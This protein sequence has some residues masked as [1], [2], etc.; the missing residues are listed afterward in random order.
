M[1]FILRKKRLMDF[2]SKREAGE[3]LRSMGTKAKGKAGEGHTYIET[4]LGVPVHK[5]G[6]YSSYLSTG[7]KKVWAT[8]RAC[9]LVASVI[10]STPFKLTKPKVDGWEADP[11][12]PEALFLHNPNPFD[13]WAELL[14]LWTYHMKLA[15]CAFW[16]KDEIDG[17]GRPTNIYP[18]LP[19]HVKIIP[20]A[21]KNIGGF[22]YQVN[23]KQIDLTPEEVIYFRRPHP[24][25]LLLGMGDIEPS[26]DLYNDFINR[27]T[28]QEKFMEHGA[29]PSGILSLKSQITPDE[30]EWGRLKSWWNKEYG[31]KKNAGKTAFLT[32]EWSYQQLGLTQQQMQSIEYGKMTIEHIFMNHGV[33]LSIAGV[34]G[35]AN[36]ATAR[37]DEINFRKY[38]IVPLLSLL[39]SKLNS[40]SSLFST[41][42]PE[43]ELA[44]KL[45]GLIDVEQVNKDYGPLVAV[46]AMTPN[47]LREAAGLQ[48]SDNPYLDQFFMGGQPIEMAGLSDIPP[49]EDATY[50]A[51]GE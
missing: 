4:Q 23:G 50:A 12:S 20:D 5:F 30:D 44:Y 2:S 16:M 10:Q 21:K 51:Q 24:T 3:A 7:C 33:P 36:Y 38:E 6:D 32:G 42:D 40:E 17:R 49:L 29:Q 14:Y 25:S 37:T 35:A 22:I 46:G 48:K 1:A 11:A 43:I 18:M 15:G 31:G 34:Q 45:S 19:H 26:E 9:H 13:S 39:V 28:Y 41:F 27:N 47:E 8:F